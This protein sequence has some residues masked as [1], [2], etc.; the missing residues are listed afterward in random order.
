MLYIC[1]ETF[2]VYSSL[3]ISETT[4][5]ATLLASISTSHIIK[6]CNINNVSF[7]CPSKAPTK[8]L[9]LITAAVLYTGDTATLQQYCMQEIQ[10]PE[11]LILNNSLAQSTAVSRI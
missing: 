3:Q 9:F 6:P 5:K 8:Y 10:L 1:L 2:E 7:Y 11:F 4:L